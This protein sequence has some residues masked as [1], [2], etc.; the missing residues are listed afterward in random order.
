[1]GQVLRGRLT[2][3][4]FTLQKWPYYKHAPLRD[5][6]SQLAFTLEK[7]HDGS[8]WLDKFDFFD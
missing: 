6:I 8:A 5:T 4:M 1:M 7:A 3:R 2:A